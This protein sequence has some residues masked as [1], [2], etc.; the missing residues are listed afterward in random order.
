MGITEIRANKNYLTLAKAASFIIILFHFLNFYVFL[1]LND[2]MPAAPSGGIIS[3]IG[4]FNM[5]GCIL[6]SF[7]APFFLPSPGRRKPLALSIVYIALVTL[8]N[9]ILRSQGVQLWIDSTTIRNIIACFSGMLLAIGYGLYFSAFLEKRE[10]EAG[11][12]FTLFL[13][14]IAYALGLVSRDIS[15]RILN[16]IGVIADPLQSMA[17]TFNFIRWLFAGI[18]VFAVITV[19]CLHLHKKTDDQ[20]TDKPIAIPP[21]SAPDK[22]V[23]ILLIC[24]SILFRGVN[25]VLEQRMFVLLTYP[26]D[27]LTPYLFITA[28]A[29]PVL[30]FF[31]ER[32]IGSF[33]KVFL[34]AA[35]AFFILL[36]CLFLFE[37]YSRFILIMNIFTSIF[38]YLIF[39]VFSFEITR[40]YAGGYLFYAISTVIHFT[41]LFSW[42]GPITNR[43]IPEGTNYTVMVIAIAASLFMLLSFRVLTLRAPAEPAKEPHQDFNNTETVKKL[44]QDYSDIESIFKK[45][46]LTRRETDVAALLVKDGLSGIEISNRLCISYGTVKRHIHSIYRKF[47]VTTRGELMAQFIQKEK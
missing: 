30:A 7:L 23:I 18:A 20:T 22:Q 42:L 6:G 35:T 40:R 21:V 32:S 47:N 37:D 36:S 16:A 44:H 19:I 38:S 25:S 43:Y 13:F 15:L 41:Y 29:L 8:P 31:I 14:A 4:V 46:K 26:A 1:I 11:R 2:F 24:L 9:V 28:A 45:F 34:P 12:R 27:T 33:L 3:R 10:A 17:L 5:L 39:I